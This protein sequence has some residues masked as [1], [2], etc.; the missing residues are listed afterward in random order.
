MPFPHEVR[1]R[2]TRPEL[3]KGDLRPMVIT[4]VEMSCLQPVRHRRAARPQH[5]MQGHLVPDAEAARRDW[6]TAKCVF[7]VVYLLTATKCPRGPS[8][9]GAP[10]S[11]IP[12]GGLLRGSDMRFS[13]LRCL[14]LRLAS[15]SSPTAHAPLPETQ[16][17]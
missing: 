4:L 9:H 1:V 13:C 12:A 7:L 10:E 8:T 17:L 6:V 15:W 5:G 3:E 2:P 14:R 16:L 11:R